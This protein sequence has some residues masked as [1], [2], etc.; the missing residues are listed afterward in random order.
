MEVNM[1]SMIMLKAEL[2]P[3]FMVGQ[4]ALLEGAMPTLDLLGIAF[5]FVYYYLKTVGALKAPKWLV[6]WYN[7]SPSAKSIKDQYDVI[8]SDFG[9]L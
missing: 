5:G 1:F 6:T 9:N 8:S 3:W 7:T 4:T 2:L